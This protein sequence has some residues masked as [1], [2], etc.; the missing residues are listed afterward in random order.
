MSHDAEAAQGGRDLGKLLPPLLMFTLLLGAV[1]TA[2]DVITGDKER[3][4]SETL[5]TTSAARSSVL[6]AKAVVV[7]GAAV[8]AGTAWVAGVVSAHALGIMGSADE[9][10]R[11]LGALSP[12][13]V[14]LVECL[15]VLLG[16][17]VAGAAMGVASWVDDYRSGSMVAGPVLLT[18]LAPS[19]LPMIDSLELSWWVVLVPVGNVTVAFRDALAGELTALGG[20]AVLLVSLGQA[21]GAFA[22][23]HRLL[24][25][26]ETFTGTADADGRRGMGRFGPDAALTFVIA[27]LVFWFLGTLA[28]RVDLVAGH[29][30]SQA[31]FAGIGVGAVAFF[32]APWARLRLARPRLGDAVASVL[33]GMCTSG[34]AATLFLLQ[35]RLLPGGM[36]LGEQFSETLGTVG[37]SLP[38][39][40]L[41]FALV[42]G[43][44]EELLFRGGLLGLADRD[45]PP[46]P[47]VLVVAAAF[48]VMHLSAYR[49][50]PTFLVGCVA[51]ALV[52][53]GR[54]LWCGILLHVT[55]NAVSLSGP[56]LF[57]VE[58]RDLIPSDLAVAGMLALALAGLVA[59][60]GRGRSE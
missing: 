40:L 17:Q 33:A 47:R 56:A 9:L 25:R 29:L 21:L 44:C 50:V 41:L 8:L 24:A 3:L 57:D 31:L 58:E 42:P 10:Q 37:D 11:A 1:Y 26:E 4:T 38:L 14:L 53:R 43:V 48:A 45:L 7:A 12:G 52:L 27:M 54:S 5:L 28:Q 49:L 15:V 13:T 46:L 2:F 16:L 20:G 34:V 39:T 32:G 22:V 60:V 59:L 30:F 36:R 6:A 19:G 55:H 18:L 23:G 35:E 51:G